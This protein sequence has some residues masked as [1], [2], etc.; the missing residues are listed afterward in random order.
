[1]KN[2]NASEHQNTRHILPIASV[3]A[4][5]VVFMLSPLQP[6]HAHRV[7]PPPVPANIEVPAGNKAFLE[8]HAVGTQD[9]ICL[10]CPNATTAAA[11]CPD[12]SGFAW[13]FFGPQATLFN[14]DEK[15]ITTHFLSPNP[16]ESGTP[17]ATWQHSRDT[18]SVWAVSIAS[19]SDPGFVEPGAIPWLLLEVVGDQDGPTG[20]KLTATTFIQRLN[21]SGGIAPSTGCTQS[22]DVGT[23]ALVP[24][25]ADYFFYK[26]GKDQVT[27][28]DAE[29]TIRVFLCSRGCFQYL[30]ETGGKLYFP[31]VVPEDLKTDG[32]PVIFTGTLLPDTTVVT[33]PEGGWR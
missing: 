7:T 29:G 5:A 13:T 14:D 17:R 19:S 31:D 11:M 2:C 25:T 23:K 8:G 6:A 28:K 15:Q 22:T 21:T 24:Y 9:Y 10:P 20:H 4:L 33:K 27:F 32:Q 3:T 30:L 18:S 16:D 12:A 1:M 26:V